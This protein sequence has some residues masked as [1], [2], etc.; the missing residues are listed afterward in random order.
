MEWWA[1]L[2]LLVK[3]YHSSCAHTNYTTQNSSGTF[4][5]QQAAAVSALFQLSPTGQITPS[6]EGVGGQA[7]SAHSHTVLSAGA[8]AGIVIGGI[9]VL[10]LLAALGY[11]IGRTYS[12]KYILRVNTPGGIA[13]QPNMA[14]KSFTHPS[15]YSGDSSGFRSTTISDTTTAGNMLASYEHGR[16]GSSPRSNNSPGFPIMPYNITTLDHISG[17]YESRAPEFHPANAMTTTMMP[18]YELAEAPVGAPEDGS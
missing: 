10:A 12:Y 18:P 15:P 16:V 14:H 6:G 2:I 8:I 9:A 17:S 5:Q 11:F 7:A 1:S 3:P 4:Q 13:S